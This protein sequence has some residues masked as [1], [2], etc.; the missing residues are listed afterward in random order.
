MYSANCTVSPA[1]P[2]HR[3]KIFSLI[4]NILSWSGQRKTTLRATV[5]RKKTLFCQY[6]NTLRFLSEARK[7]RDSENYIMSWNVTKR[8]KAETHK[9]PPLDISEIH[10]L[11]YTAMKT[12]TSHR[13]LWSDKVQ[14]LTWYFLGSRIRIW[15][16][17]HSTLNIL[18]R[19]ATKTMLQFG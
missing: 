17:D 14:H 19:Q 4:L 13:I 2:T 1:S 6:H 16:G 9:V 3:S 7:L 18:P 8:N 15:F 11:S 12:K 5:M 10:C